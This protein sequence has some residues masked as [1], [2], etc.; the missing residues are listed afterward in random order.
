MMTEANGGQTPDGIS[1]GDI[2][3]WY[4]GYTLKVRATSCELREKNI[5]LMMTAR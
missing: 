4:S 3:R 2:K 1:G 5:M